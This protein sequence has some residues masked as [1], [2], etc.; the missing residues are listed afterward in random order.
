MMKKSTYYTLVR[1]R[2]PEI[3]EQSGKTPVTEKLNDHRYI[4]MLNSKLGEELAE[5]Q[6]ENNVEELAD[7]V[8]VVYAILE[9]RGVTLAQFEKIRR[10]KVDSKGAF[11]ERLLLKEVIDE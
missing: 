8:E 5:Y 10:S 7:I 3:I 11:K 4:Q 9:F 2:I 1:D 6:G